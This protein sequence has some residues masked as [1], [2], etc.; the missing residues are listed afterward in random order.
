MAAGGRPGWRA[1]TGA[2]TSRAAARA[3]PG[4]TRR[5]RVEYGNI[6]DLFGGGQG[7][8]DFFQAIF[9]GAPGAPTTTGRR[10]PAGASQLSP[11]PRLRARDRGHPGGSLPRRTA[12]ARR[13]RPTP[14]SQDPCR[15]KDR[16]RGFAWPAKAR[17]GPGGARGNIYLVVKVLPDPNFERRATTSIQR[18]RSTCSPHC[19]GAKR[20]SR[21]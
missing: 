3:Q 15:R 9:G 18:S 20:A 10:L 2:S 7:F 4:W 8:S 19:W 12:S 13:R 11:T 21:P 1:S 17:L 6:N 16:A 5:V 14:R